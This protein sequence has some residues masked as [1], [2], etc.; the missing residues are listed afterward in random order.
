MGGL[1]VLEHSQRQLTAVPVSEHVHQLVVQ[2]RIL[3][4]GA[5][6]AVFVELG[7]EEVETLLRGRAEIGPG[8]G[9]SDLRHAALRL[10]R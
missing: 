3:G 1:H 5:M 7:G 6:G 9:L 10:G 2:A 8:G 4:G